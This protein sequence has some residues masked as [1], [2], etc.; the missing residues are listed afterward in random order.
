M[1]IF[2]GYSNVPSIMDLQE[3]I[4]RVGQDNFSDENGDNIFVS[5]DPVSADQIS[6]LEKHLHVFFPDEYK[7]LLVNYGTASFFK[8]KFMHP[9]MIRPLG[10]DAEEM[11]GFIPFATDHARNG[12]AFNLNMEIERYDPKPFAH[13][14]VAR[15]FSDWLV[16]HHEYNRRVH[17]GKDVRDHPYFQAAFD[18]KDSEERIKKTI[19]KRNKSW[20]QFWK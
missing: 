6:E 2:A 13:G 1:T 17:E 7:S 12:F 8:A 15:S 14:Y 19:A 16:V 9:A 11:E 18:L 10:Y 20:W 5:G 4:T 3:F